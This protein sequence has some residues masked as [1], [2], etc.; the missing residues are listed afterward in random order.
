MT[1]ILSIVSYKNYN[2]SANEDFVTFFNFQVNYV[3]YWR[4]HFQNEIQSIVYLLN[5][6]EH[7]Y[8]IWDLENE[9]HSIWDLWISAF[10]NASTIVFFEVGRAGGQQF[11]VGSRKS[12]GRLSLP[13]Y[14]SPEKFV[15]GGN[16]MSAA[17]NHVIFS[18]MYKV[19]HQKTLGRSVNHHWTRVS[20]STNQ[21]S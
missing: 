6:S 15:G 12:D 4:F 10:K 7:I 3:L 16:F 14:F 20:L 17:T 5:G 21:I 19:L 11:S 1:K 2:L 8:R 13:E 18:S 9:V